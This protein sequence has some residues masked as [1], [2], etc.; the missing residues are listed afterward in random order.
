MRVL[1]TDN[2]APV[3]L[4]L[5]R[6]H[7][8]EADVQLKKAPDELKAL[9]KEADGWIIRSGTTI[10]SELIKAAPSLKV[11]GRAGVGVDNIDLTAATRRGVLVVNAPDGNTIS[12]AE[13]TC[14]MMLALARRIPRAASSLAG[15]AWERKQFGGAELDGKTLGVIGVGKIGRAVAQRMQAFGMTVLGFDPVMAPETAER[16]HIELVPL[17]RIWADADVITVHTP[18]NDATRGLLG[19]ETLAQCKDGVRIVNIA[20]GGIVDEAAL[21][22]ALES[23]K[24]AGAA[25]DVYSQEPP[26][27]ELQAL[28]AHPHVVATPHIAASTE[29]AQEKVAVQIVEQVVRALRGEP[30]TTPVNA[31]AIRMAAQPE[32]APY[33]NLAER[34]GRLAS[35]LVEGTVTRVTVRCAGETVGHYAEVLTVG[36]LAG[37][38]ARWS[39]EP[40]NL[41]NAPALAREMGLQVDEHRQSAQDEFANV[42]AVTLDTP[43]GTRTVRGTVLGQSDVRL[44]GVDAYPIE[45][46][47]DGHLLF[48]QNVDRPGMLATVG[49]LLA[50]AGINIAGL[51]LGREAPG[52]MALTVMTLDEV[53][54]RAVVQQIETLEGVHDVRIASV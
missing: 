47:L 42:V 9:A 35:Q 36:A 6:E 11:I 8:L 26:P 4:D 22:D 38:M 16:L 3:A 49:K 32:A 20:R 7:G 45:V 19:T 51:T 41:I 30:V 17:D 33:L 15:G 28:L 37:V 46:T 54:P 1:I 27:A 40:V 50:D 18:L 5:L 24:V 25:L 48:Y 29:E 39:E 12:T 2:L 10:T 23:G 53:L 52:A 14:A 43:A 31:G 34:L 21:L 13:H 44:V